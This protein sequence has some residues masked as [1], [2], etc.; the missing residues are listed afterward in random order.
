MTSTI[1]TGDPISRKIKQVRTQ[2]DL[3]KEDPAF[4][5]AEY[6]HGEHYL[7]LRFYYTDKETGELRPGKNGIT[8]R[9][10]H[11]LNAIVALIDAFNQATGTNI[12]LMPDSDFDIAVMDNQLSHDKDEEA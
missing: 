12:S 4:A 7:G 5:T 11:G 10:D 3:G 6:F 8:V 1:G 9:L 2:V